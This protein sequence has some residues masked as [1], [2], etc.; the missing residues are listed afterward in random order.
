MKNGLVCSAPV[1]SRRARARGTDNLLPD[2]SKLGPY[3]IVAPIGAA[4]TGV[5]ALSSASPERIA[6]S[7]KMASLSIRL[8]S[9][10]DHANAKRFHS[11]DEFE[12]MELHSTILIDGRGKVRWARTGG[13]PFMELDFLVGEIKRVNGVETTVAKGPDRK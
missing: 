11:Y 9:D 10:P 13:D 3:A 4:G 2:G 12:E 5:V 7:E 6:S 1:G 8:L